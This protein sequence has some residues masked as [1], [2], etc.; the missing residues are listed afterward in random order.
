MPTITTSEMVPA[1]AYVSTDNTAAAA[2]LPVDGVTTTWRTVYRVVAP[3]PPGDLFQVHAEASFTNDVGVDPGTRKVVG[4]RYTVGVGIHLWYYDVDYD[5]PVALNDRMVRIGD[6]E[7]ENVTVDTHH[8]PLDITRWLAVPDTWP[9]GH[10][11]AFALRADA[12]SSLWKANGGGDVLTVDR[13]GLIGAQRWTVPAPVVD[14]PRWQQL[15]ALETRV[16]ALEAAVPSCPPP[17][18]A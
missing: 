3:C 16:A 9:V 11:I 4:T 14:D 17:P 1:G 12:H 2:G 10:R 8:L 15:A 13:L 18:P 7:G 6:S 5:G